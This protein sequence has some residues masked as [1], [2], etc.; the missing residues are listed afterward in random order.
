[1]EMAGGRLA[2]GAAARRRTRAA[3]DGRRA[4]CWLRGGREASRGRGASEGSLSP[5]HGD[6]RPAGHG[7]R[8]WRHGGG[9]AY[10][11]E[12]TAFRSGETP[13]GGSIKHTT[14]R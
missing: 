5:A 7:N 6:P 3:E 8:R 4:G 13:A 11:G 14:R 1:M 9:S 12:A 2:T 10:G